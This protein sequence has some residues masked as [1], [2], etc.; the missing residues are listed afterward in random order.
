LEYE[1][2]TRPDNVLHHAVAA[3]QYSSG[4]R[5][6][7]AVLNVDEAASFFDQPTLE[8]WNLAASER[9]LL[10]V[11]EMKLRGDREG[12]GELL[13]DAEV[14]HTRFL[15]QPTT[16]TTNRLGAIFGELSTIR[17]TMKGARTVIRGSSYLDAPALASATLLASASSRETWLL[18]DRLKV[19]SLPN[20]SSTPKAA[21]VWVQ[22]GQSTPEAAV[23]VQ[24]ILEVAAHSSTQSAARV[25]LKD[26]GLQYSGVATTELEFLNPRQSSSPDWSFDS[27]ARLDRSRF[28]LTF[29]TSESHFPVLLEQLSRPPGLPIEIE[30]RS[31]S[32]PKVGSDTYGPL[33]ATLGL[34]ALSTAGLKLLPSN[35][36]ANESA[37]TLDAIAIGDEKDVI[38][39][40]PPLS[41]IAGSKVSL[42]KYVPTQSTFTAVEAVFD[43]A[44]QVP[45]REKLE[46]AS[47]QWSILSLKFTNLVDVKDGRQVKEL[48]VSVDAIGSDGSI[49]YNHVLVSLARFGLAEASQTIPLLLPPGFRLRYTSQ[50]VFSDGT[51]DVGPTDETSAVD[52]RLR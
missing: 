21:R 44:G 22:D 24:F 42:P 29:R 40:D 10:Q 30:W 49:I 9:L 12:L 25:A 48:R 5:R 35:L 50:Y 51:K 17:D 23:R 11:K 46:F 18:P 6:V 32:D 26:R 2:S 45:A 8:Q 39:L 41:V 28:V 20:S 33:R 36:L 7:Y 1:L 31:V 13:R 4:Y 52:I 38:S 19:S 14:L 3:I 16:T 47:P 34:Y 37:Y 43:L 15:A 27:I